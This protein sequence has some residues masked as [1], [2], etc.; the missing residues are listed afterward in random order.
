MQIIAEDETRLTFKIRDEIS[1]DL[2]RT[3]TSE[4]IKTVEG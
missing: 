4:R 2:A 1:K 3:R